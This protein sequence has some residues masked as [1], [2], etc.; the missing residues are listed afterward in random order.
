MVV[1]ILAEEK[2]L[3]QQE[4]RERLHRLQDEKYHVSKGE[5]S[6]ILQDFENR[7]IVETRS[8]EGNSIIYSVNLNIAE[9]EGIV[10]LGFGDSI[11][12]LIDDLDSRGFFDEGIDEKDIGEF[13]KN[14]SG[15]PAV[16]QFLKDF[17]S[18]EYRA[19]EPKNRIEDLEGD[20]L[21]SGIR[22]NSLTLL[23]DVLTEIFGEKVGKKVEFTENGIKAK[24]DPYEFSRLLTEDN[25]GNL[26]EAIEKKRRYNDFKDH[27]ETGEDG[28]FFHVSEVE[29]V[30]SCEKCS[31]SIE[32]KAYITRRGVEGYVLTCGE[33]KDVLMM[34][35]GLKG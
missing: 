20:S 28:E 9:Q 19:T 35:E 14:N 32:D 21:D 17:E 18:E 8:G 7:N 1:E 26:A 27:L 2:E 33:C 30:H 29:H 6:E 22:F 13:L 31:D 5:F 16:S 24:A 4:I 25:L 15:N 11:N 3:K 23:F 12:K 34:E 10:D